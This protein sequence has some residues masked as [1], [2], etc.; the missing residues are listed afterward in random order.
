MPTAATRP[1]FL[2][3][4]GQ[5]RAQVRACTCA[6]TDVAA[7]TGIL[8]LIMARQRGN[9]GSDT[10]VEPR[11]CRGTKRTAGV[12]QDPGALGLTTWTSPRAGRGDRSKVYTS[13][14]TQL[15]RDQ[16][17]R[18]PGRWEEEEQGLRSALTQPTGWHPSNTCPHPSQ[19]SGNH[20]P[21]FPRTPCF[22][23]QLGGCLGPK[24]GGSYSP[25]QKRTDRHGG[26]GDGD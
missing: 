18:S 1:C 14:G 4:N 24:T 15:S 3:K 9:R 26:R 25:A 19:A 8:V 17:K 20:S 6:P 21:R 7:S 11:S 2:G 16:G 22:H 23:S 13:A 10:E 5:V 12:K